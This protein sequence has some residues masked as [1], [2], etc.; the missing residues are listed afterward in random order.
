MIRRYCKVFLSSPVSLYEAMHSQEKVSYLI[1]TYLLSADNL[2]LP[3]AIAALFYIY[4]EM[5]IN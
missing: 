5:K 1:F 4:F 2:I 3:K